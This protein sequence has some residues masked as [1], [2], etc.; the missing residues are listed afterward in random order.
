MHFTT[1]TGRENYSLAAD[2][3]VD[4][5]NIFVSMIR[6]RVVRSLIHTNYNIFGTYTN[7]LESINH[8]IEV[9]CLSQ[10][11]FRRSQKLLVM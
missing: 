4:N 6:Q 3:L 8:I 10:H 5:I 11:G 2:A 1:K 9:Y 7:P